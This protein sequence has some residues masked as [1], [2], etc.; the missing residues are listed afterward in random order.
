MTF[1]HSLISISQWIVSISGTAKLGRLN[2]NIGAV[3]VKS[4]PADLKQIDEALSKIEIVGGRRVA[5]Y[6]K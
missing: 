3:D 5:A 4:T 6:T 2:E 1:P